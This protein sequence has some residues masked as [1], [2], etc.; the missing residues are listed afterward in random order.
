VINHPYHA[1]Q[2]TSAYPYSQG[3]HIPRGHYGLALAPTAVLAPLQHDG[4]GLLN[5]GPAGGH[6]ALW[7]ARDLNIDRGA[8][9]TSE[10][11]TDVLN[12]YGVAISMNGKD[13]SVDKSSLSA[14]GVREVRG[15]V[16]ACLRYTCGTPQGTGSVFQS[17]QYQALSQRTG[18]MHRMCGVLREGHLSTGGLK[19]KESF[20]YGTVKFSE[21][22]SPCKAGLCE[23]LKIPTGWNIT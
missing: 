11:F 15:P 3:V 13:R 16:P 23:I 14:A 20:T 10:A 19:P 4:Y 2:Q 9:F 21:F 7:H 5:R 8:Q 12:D 18:P 22:I 17:L 1:W 6:T